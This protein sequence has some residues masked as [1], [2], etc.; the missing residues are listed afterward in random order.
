MGAW[1]AAPP[2]L[3][4]RAEPQPLPG[5]QLPGWPLPGDGVEAQPAGPEPELGTVPLW[6]SRP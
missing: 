5:R 3:G 2:G 1:R 4:C 6:R